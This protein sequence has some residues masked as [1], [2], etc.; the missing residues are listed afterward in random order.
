MAVLDDKEIENIM[1]DG[2]STES[3]EYVHSTVQQDG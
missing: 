1:L 3:H 2:R